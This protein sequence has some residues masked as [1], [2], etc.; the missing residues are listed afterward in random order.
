LPPSR[1]HQGRAVVILG[2]QPIL[3]LLL[4]ELNGTLGGGGGS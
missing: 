1:R 3:G 4:R 2:S